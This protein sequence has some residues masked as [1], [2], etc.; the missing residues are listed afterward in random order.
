M[1]VVVKAWQSTICAHLRGL[2]IVPFVA[3]LAAVFDHLPRKH[4]ER[5]LTITCSMF[6]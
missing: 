1:H 5:T 4:K 2:F 3:T 6:A